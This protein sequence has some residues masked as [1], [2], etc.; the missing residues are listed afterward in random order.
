MVQALRADHEKIKQ[1]VGKDLIRSY[2][3]SLMREVFQP[4]D[5][6]RFHEIAAAAATEAS[7]TALVAAAGAAPPPSARSATGTARKFE[8]DLSSTST[9]CYNASVDNIS[10]ALGMLAVR[11][12]YV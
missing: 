4:H 6:E 1:A 5:V 11:P 3:L 7:S 10:F 2:D 9:V 8:L 12:L